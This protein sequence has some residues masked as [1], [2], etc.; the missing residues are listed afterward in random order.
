MRVDPRPTKYPHMFRW[1]H[2]YMML[3]IQNRSSAGGPNVIS[4]RSAQNPVYGDP[5]GHKGH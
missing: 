2:G 1:F 3:P 4:A 5:T